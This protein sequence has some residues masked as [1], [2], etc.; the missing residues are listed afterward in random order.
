M[1]EQYI[2]YSLQIRDIFN[3]E[4]TQAME[5]SIGPMASLSLMSLVSMVNPKVS[6]L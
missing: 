4:D 6:D 3:S 2:L 1:H 5:S